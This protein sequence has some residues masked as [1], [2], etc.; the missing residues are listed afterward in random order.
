[1]KIKTCTW[2]TTIYPSTPPIDQSYLIFIDVI[3]FR[4]SWW[5]VVREQ[6]KKKK[7]QITLLHLPYLDVFEYNGSS[8]IHL[9]F[10]WIRRLKPASTYHVKHFGFPFNKIK[11]KKSRIDVAL[12]NENLYNVGVGYTHRIVPLIFHKNRVQFLVSSRCFFILF[13]FISR[14]YFVS[15]S[16]FFVFFLCVCRL[17]HLIHLWYIMPP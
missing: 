15:I 12:S 4:F 6:K 8:T 16:I 13:H 1:M 14:W 11:K 7:S 10:I 2:H 3:T 5:V 9:N 17:P